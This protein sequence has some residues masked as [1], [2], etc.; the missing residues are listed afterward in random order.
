M[1]NNKTINKALVCE[2]CNE[3][4]AK[5]E[6]FSED[7]KLCYSC[8]KQKEAVDNDECLVCCGKGAMTR[9]GGQCKDCFDGDE[10]VEIF[11]LIKES[12]LS[13]VEDSA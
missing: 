5:A 8:F 7:P 9:Y 2:G 1:V 13:E 4:I 10:I 3:K 12:E 11:G 6:D